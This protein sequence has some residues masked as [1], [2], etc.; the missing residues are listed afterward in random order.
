VAYWRKLKQREPQLVTICHGLKLPAKDGRLRYA[1]C[2][3]T[4][5]AFRL[6]QS[7]S[8]K[9]A[10]PFRLWLAQLGKE[11]IDEIE[12][13]EL[14]QARMKEILKDIKNEINPLKISARI[15][16]GISPNVFQG[17]FAKSAA[18]TSGSKEAI[19][20]EYLIKGK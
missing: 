2:V 11:R 5:S 20:S 14:A 7:I 16:A 6:I 9:K 19:F 4:K 13:P 18:N 15:R 3:N 8:S 1:D 17:T 12:N 10:E